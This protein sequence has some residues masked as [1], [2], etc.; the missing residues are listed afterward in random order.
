M[1]VALY[2]LGCKLN[3]AETESLAD[4][5]G[6]AGYQIVAPNEKA[7][8]YIANTCTVTHVADR[9]SRH[10]LRMARRRN[11]NAIVVATGCYV[12]R[13]PRELALLA[14]L[15]LDNEEKS[16]VLEAVEQLLPQKPLLSP[17][18]S[19]NGA[20]PNGKSQR[21]RSIIKIQDGCNT[22]CSYCIVPMVRPHEYS[23]PPAATIEQ[24]RAKVTAGYRE[25]VLTGTKVGCYSYEGITLSQLVRR[26][27]EET[28]I[29]RLRLSSLQPQ[30]ISPDLLDL[31]QD[32]RLCRHFHLALQSGSELVLQQ[33]KRRYTLND[34]VKTMDAIR[35]ALPQAA[36]TTDVMVGFPGESDEDFEQSYQFCQQAGFAN[37]HVFPYSRRKGTAADSMPNQVGNHTKQL[38]TWRMLN[39]ARECQQRF[40]K[41]FVGE[42]ETSPGS[43]TYSGFTD[44][45][46]RVF[47][48][49]Q[50]PLSNQIATARI[51]T[52][53]KQGVLGELTDE[54]TDSGKAELKN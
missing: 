47:T 7:D 26:I 37:I 43:K 30:E 32:R 18:Q 34:Y 51:L 29:E 23:L 42:K 3:Q 11:P 13:A 6:E 31:W 20:S 36:I 10:W 24:I 4:R 40:Y 48:K 21:V 49:S 5:F 53:C 15:L 9:K 52:P 17:Q 1:K 28:G 19:P 8:I 41:Q 46:I 33:M 44:N 2:T 16:R 39:L 22:P 38:R 50:Q 25:V 45:Y 54:N 12:Q 27:L 14:D 35:T